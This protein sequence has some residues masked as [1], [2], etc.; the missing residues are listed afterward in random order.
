MNTQMSSHN[1]CHTNSEYDVGVSVALISHINETVCEYEDDLDLTKL[2]HLLDLY[3]AYL[4]MSV[5]D[6][7]DPIR[8]NSTDMDTSTDYDQDQQRNHASFEQFIINS[9]LLKQATA[10]ISKEHGMAL[11]PTAPLS[12]RRY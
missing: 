6:T 12:F 1:G 7:D 10:A 5:T 8:I 11:A 2:I 9:H 4:V 3:R